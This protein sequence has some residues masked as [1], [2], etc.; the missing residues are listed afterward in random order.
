MS[1]SSWTGVRPIDEKKERRDIRASLFGGIVAI[2]IVLLNL[3]APLINQSVK[4]PLA[5]LM[6]DMAP[7]GKIPFEV[8]STPVLTLFL[9]GIAVKAA[10]IIA[11]AVLLIQVV[12]IYSRGDFFT[13]TAANLVTAM[14]WAVFAYCVGPF[15]EMLGANMLASELNLDRWFDMNTLGGLDFGIWY[16]LL[17]VLGMMSVML[18]RAARMQEDQE[19]LI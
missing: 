9:V 17:I 18:R 1:K 15:F 4:H 11:V 19:G 5:F 7:E 6:G 12:R 2:F 13:L 8:M 14:S 10:S 16:L 3:Q